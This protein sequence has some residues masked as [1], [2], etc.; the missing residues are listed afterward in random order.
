MTT[1]PLLHFSALF[2]DVNCGTSYTSTTYKHKTHRT[3]V[4]V[5][6]YAKA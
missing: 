1:P 6:V 5:R 4:R 3:R 2:L